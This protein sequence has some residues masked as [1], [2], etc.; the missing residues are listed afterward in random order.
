MTQH[1]A[2]VR[3]HARLLWGWA[4]DKLPIQKCSKAG[5]RSAWGM[6]D[7]STSVYPKGPYSFN[8]VITFLPYKPCLPI[9][10]AG[11][12]SCYLTN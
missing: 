6:H 8:L 2:L 1:V 4:G 12:H 9:T 7:L 10:Q 5:A 3:I 11:H